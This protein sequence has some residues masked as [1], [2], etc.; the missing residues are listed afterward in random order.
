MFLMRQFL[1][2]VQPY[3]GEAYQGGD[4]AGSRLER[5][6]AQTAAATER[7]SLQRELTNRRTELAIVFERRS[8]REK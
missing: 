5:A 8:R 4:G 6:I 2:A 1:N 3:R 7:E